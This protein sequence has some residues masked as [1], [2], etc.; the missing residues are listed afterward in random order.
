M[1]ARVRIVYRYARI[2][3]GLPAYRAYHLAT[4]R[5]VLVAGHPYR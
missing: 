2:A 1:N 4:G 3:L 5:Y